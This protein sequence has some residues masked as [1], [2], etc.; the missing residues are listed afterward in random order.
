M[1]ADLTKW[2]L[3]VKHIIFNT[4]YLILFNPCVYPLLISPLS[5]LPLN[6]FHP[7]VLFFFFFFLLVSHMYLSVLLSDCMLFFICFWCMCTIFS[8]LLIFFLLF[9]PFSFLLFFS[10]PISK[11]YQ[12]CNFYIATT[13]PLQ[14]Y[15]CKNIISR[16]SILN[17]AVL[18]ILKMS[19]ILKLCSSYRGRSVNQPVMLLW[20]VNWYQDHTR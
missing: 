16:C 9:S 10:P 3:T 1:W 17:K 14:D 8:L 13:G 4:Q 7:L 11:I 2:F 18:K 19:C 15:G 5:F 6:I 20:L 12:K